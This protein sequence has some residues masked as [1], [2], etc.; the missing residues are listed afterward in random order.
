MN[1]SALWA[2]RGPRK[3]A[4]V[5]TGVCH[6]PLFCRVGVSR[7]AAREA[8]NQCQAHMGRENRRVGA[9]VN[10]REKQKGLC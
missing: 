2:L 4:E 3:A 7:E 6:I 9:C 8:T 5:V 10:D 1:V